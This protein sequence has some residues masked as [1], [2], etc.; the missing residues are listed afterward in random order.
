MKEERILIFKVENPCS[1]NCEIKDIT[2]CKTCNVKKRYYEA[3]T[4]DTAI[5]KMARAMC[6]RNNQNCKECNFYKDKN[7]CKKYISGT[8]AYPLLA[9]AALKALLEE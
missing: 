1:D 7:R 2:S 5:E 8:S 6:M 4:Y 3:K 9:E